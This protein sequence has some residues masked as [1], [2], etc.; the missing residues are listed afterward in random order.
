M[1]LRAKKTEPPLKDIVPKILTIAGQHILPHMVGH[2]PQERVEFT[3]MIQLKN[4]QNTQ[5]V[6]GQEVLVN[7]QLPITLIQVLL[8]G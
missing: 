2:L 7:V 8:V 1:D 6:L 4:V 3:P 5:D